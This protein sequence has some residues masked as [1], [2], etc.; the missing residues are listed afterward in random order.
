MVKEIIIKRLSLILVSLLLI[1]WGCEDYN[2]K[3]TISPTVSIQSPITNQPINELVTIVVETNDN[4]GIDRVEFYINE[5]LRF[6]DRE[7]PYEYEWDTRQYEDY[8]EN[9][10]KVTSYDNSD[11]STTSQPIIYIIDNSTPIPTP[12]ELNPI[13]FENGS[14]I[15]SWS[16]N[17]DNDFKSY[18]LY[19]SDSQ[20]MSNQIGIFQTEE[21]TEINYTIIGMEQ[22][23]RYYQVVV[24]DTWGINTLSNVEK[25]YGF[26]LFSKTYGGSSY[27]Y[28]HSVQQT[29]DDGYII[30][31]ETKSYANGYSDAWLIKTDSEGN[32]E[33][34]QTFGG[35]FYDNGYSVQQTMDS[36]YA[37]TGMGPSGTWLI[38]TNYEGNE[39]WNQSF[40]GVHNTGYSVQQTLDGGYVITGA[41]GYSSYDIG[42]IK[43]D[44]QGNE[45][46]NQIYGGSE[47]DKGKFVQQTMDGGYIIIGYTRSYGS[48][49]FDVWLIKTD[50]EGT[51]EWNQTYGGS[52]NDYGYSVQQTM[53]DG[54]IIVGTTAS[55]G[56]GNSDVWLIKTDSQG[57]E[58]WNQTYGGS[59]DDGGRSFQQTSDGGYVIAGYTQ[60]YGNGNS[61]V[62]LIKT[63]SQGNEEWNQTFGGA[64]TDYSYSVEQTTDG[65]Y[66]ITG[67]TQSYGNGNTDVWLIKTGPEGNIENI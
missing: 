44:S 29:M 62:W 30:T 25:G 2:D 10:V 43:T 27:D 39:E 20:D 21:I 18:T 40:E 34:N 8:S 60:S 32:E 7:S 56:N 53:D 57:N 46:C 9:T 4:E 26:T 66:V 35:N 13:V 42:L 33:W 55:Y 58:E 63:D 37:I 67:Y 22:Q 65:G 6:I 49:N 31:G 5:T 59:D 52:N 48:G 15:I 14:F 36:G 61:D 19:E 3:D 1:Y 12:S 28:G 11:N 54:F 50:S 38:K 41:Y 51:E 16:Q 45:E 23:T 47:W 17:N 24:S 64:S